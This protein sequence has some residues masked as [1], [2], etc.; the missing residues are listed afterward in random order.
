MA[1]DS[2]AIGQNYHSDSESCRNCQSC[3]RSGGDVP[4]ATR[5][6]CFTESSEEENVESCSA[7]WYVFG[8][9]CSEH[10]SSNRFPP[11]RCGKPGSMHSLILVFTHTRDSA[12][13]ADI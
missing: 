13:S 7:N 6:A 1:G 5:Q 3:S 11:H 8:R 4:G 9:I 2:A 12:A 10:D